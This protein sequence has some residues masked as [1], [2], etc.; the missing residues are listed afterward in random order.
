MDSNGSVAISEGGIRVRKSAV[1]H[2]DSAPVIKFTIES[3]RDEPVAARIHD[4]L[5]E[6][7]DPA[8]IEFDV[9][10]AAEGWRTTD[11]GLAFSR[12]LAPNDSV[13]TAFVVPETETADVGRYL[14]PPSIAAVQSVEAEALENGEGPP[15]WRGGPGAVQ[16]V[17]PEPTDGV[18]DPVGSNDAVES[19]AGAVTSPERLVAVPAYNEE[20]S[21]ADVV[22]RAAEHADQVLVVDDGSGDETAAEAR[23]AGADVVDH[24]HNRGYGAA[25]QTIFRE[26]DRRD[27][28]HLIVI[29]GDGQ[30]DPRDIERL[31]DRQRETGAEIVIGS[32][33]ADDR[34]SVIPLYRRFGLRVVNLMTNLSMGTLQSS[35]AVRDTQSG[36]RAYDRQAIRSLA[37][38]D[39]IGDRM[40]A[41]TDILYHAHRHGYDIEEIGTEIS[42]DVENGSS[43]NPLSHGIMLISNILQIIERERPI[44]SLGIPGFVSAFV[45][46][47]FFYWA[48]SNFIQNG[49]FP[50]GL[51]MIAV[52]FT[53]GGVFACFTAITLH[54]L[55]QFAVSKQ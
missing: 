5:P 47:G 49:V 18:V 41:S 51:T 16:V 27:A 55:N 22:V 6:G 38:D 43:H 10:D 13:L 17:G 48:I 2:G 42:Y 31:V 36:F 19:P 37:T 24:E 52:F 25:L 23:A 12:V 40:H 29:D 21:I 15:L 26:A 1:V 28:K 54:A 8:T 35:S 4:R 44:A 14:S 46:L 30:H 9:S 45:G 53:L 20:Y 7:V 32:R 33:F 3:D 11:G 50:V 34:E 39:T